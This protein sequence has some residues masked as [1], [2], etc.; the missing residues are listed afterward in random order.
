MDQEQNCRVITD[1]KKQK[2]RNTR[3]SIFLDGEFAFGISEEAYV[4]FALFRGRELSQA[5]LD[6]V[7]DWENSYQARQVALRYVNARMRSRLEIRKKLREKEFS[8]ATVDATLEF[9]SE[10]NMVDDR[11]FARAWVNDQL[12]KRPLGQGRLKAGLLEKGIDRTTV[13]EI[14][15][16]QFAGDE[17]YEQAFRAAEKKASTIRHDDPLKWERSMSSFLAGRGFSWGVVKS[18]LEHY[19]E[20]R[21][22]S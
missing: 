7:L 15:S 8:E 12:L 17:E 18:V 16:E 10:Y 19:R 9:L 22:T 5:F 11:A 20:E 6:E 3:R 1:V 2:K 21:R 4:K 13:Q 14:L